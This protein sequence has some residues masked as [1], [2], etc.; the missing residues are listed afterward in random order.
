MSISTCLLDYLSLGFLLQQFEI[1]K[2]GFELTSTI[3][4][5]FQRKRLTECTSQYFKKEY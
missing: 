3:I 5:V 4:L 2:D 1:G